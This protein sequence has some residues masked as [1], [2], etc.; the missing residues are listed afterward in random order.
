M[1][2]TKAIALELDRRVLDPPLLPADPLQREPVEEAERWGDEVLQPAAR[3]IIWSALKRD[4]APIRSYLEG[5][6]VGV[7]LSV[8]AASTAPIAVLAA[9]FN[10]ATDA[11]VVADLRA[12]PA[13]IDHVDSLI[14]D[15]V[16]GGEEPNVADFQIATSLALL[17]TMDDVRPLFAGRPAERLANRLVPA[18]PGHTP[19]VLPPAWLEPIAASTRPSG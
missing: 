7:P 13:T 19:P 16:I 8:A 1:Q 12:L 10:E 15:G 4:R 6:R 5:S 3:R 17:L 2:G 11:N 14:S 18:F 9:R